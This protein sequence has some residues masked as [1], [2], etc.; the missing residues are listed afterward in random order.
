MIDDRKTNKMFGKRKLW[1]YLTK[2]KTTLFQK[3][4][5]KENKIKLTKET[6][7]ERKLT[8]I[9]SISL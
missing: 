7:N 6:S 1:K 4:N 3:Y 5:S 9:L 8:Q 2:I